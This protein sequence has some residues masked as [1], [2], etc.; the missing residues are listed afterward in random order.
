MKIPK[1]KQNKWYTKKQRVVLPP[2]ED[3]H[4]CNKK[5]FDNALLEYGKNYNMAITPPSKLATI[6]S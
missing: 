3:I 1:D 2:M 4:P 5:A 6:T